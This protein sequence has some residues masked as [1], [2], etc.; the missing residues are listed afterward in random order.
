MVSAL[1]RICKG[2][3]VFRYLLILLSLLLPFV[4]RAQGD[5]VL[6]PLDRITPDSAGS[7]AQIARLGSGSARSLAWSPDGHTLGIASSI[8][9]W[10][11]DASIP[12]SSPVLLELPAGA[13]S[14]A[15]SA[16]HIAAGSDDGTVHVWDSASL[17][18]LA[19]FESHL[20]A[21]ASLA[22]SA[23]GSLLASGDSSGVVRLWNMDSLTEYA[24]LESL[25]QSYASPDQ[26]AFSASGGFARIGYCDSVEMVSPSLQRR[27]IPGFMCPLNALTFESPTA[28][29]AI[30]DS[31]SAY[32][33]DLQTGQMAQRSIS[34]PSDPPAEVTDPTGTL[35]A[36]GR[37]DGTVRLLDA[38]AGG[39]RARLFGHIR[40]VTAVAFSPDG[41][42]I[43]SA[44]LDRAIH[45]W[46][47]TAALA[48]PDTPALVSLTGH[49]SGVT[50]LA[51]NADGTLLA[52]SGYDATLR[53][54]GI[55]R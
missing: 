55:P 10:L 43:A 49:A 13:A 46:D 47:V 42:L 54:W 9:V 24:T 8:G 52:S 23:S 40:A 15:L 14:L 41:R 12:E 34:Q 33:W 17:S 6:P 7:L 48:S 31:G 39:E 1:S 29:T 3:T 28:V 19:S 22:F 27:A 4:V 11:R 5:F 2:M 21:V 16:R 18:P 26:L 37:S 36:Q 45:L 32:T 44:S 38:A 30:S 53:L 51:F 50:A 25:G 35:I 20:Y